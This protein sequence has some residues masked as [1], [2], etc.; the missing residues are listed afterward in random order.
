MRTKVLIEL[1]EKTMNRIKLWFLHALGLVSHHSRLVLKSR[2][3]APEIAVV[4]LI[5]LERHHIGR[6]VTCLLGFAAVYPAYTFCFP[7]LFL[8]L[9]AGS[10]SLMVALRPNRG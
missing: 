4:P 6:S 1:L 9:Y 5:S 3:P 2:I 8:S 7:F 10:R